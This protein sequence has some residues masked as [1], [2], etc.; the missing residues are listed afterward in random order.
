VP[1]LNANLGVTEVMTG[2]EIR[3]KLLADVAE[4]APKVTE[5]GPL[6]APIGTVTTMLLAVAKSTGAMTPLNRTVFADGVL[7]KPCP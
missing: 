4:A 1:V 5:I 2:M 7:L 3:T 6:F